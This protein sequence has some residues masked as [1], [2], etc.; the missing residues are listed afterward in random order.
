M[1][2]DVFSDLEKSLHSGGNV[3]FSQFRDFH[4][5]RLTR[6]DYLDLSSEVEKIIRL[7]DA[8]SPPGEPVYFLFKNRGLGYASILAC[9]ISGRTFIPLSMKHPLNHIARTVSLVNSRVL[10][11]DDSTISTATCIQKLVPSLDI[12]CVDK[13]GVLIRGNGSMGG[14][15]LKRFNDI[16]YVLFTSG[17]TGSPKG[18]LIERANLNHYLNGV[19]PVIS[20]EKNDKCT[21]MFDLN[22]DLAIG[23][24]LS[25]I[26][27]GGSLYPLESNELP[28]IE[29]FL[30][31]FEPTI[32]S[33]T[34]STVR[35]IQ[36]L[37]FLNK[38]IGSIRK[39]F[40]G[41]E[42]LTV[43]IAKY[44]KSKCPQSQIHNFY[45]PTE[46]TINVLHYEWTEKDQINVPLGRAIPS[47]SVRIVN[48]GGQPA[49]PKEVGEINVGGAQVARGYLNET[50]DTQSPFF[51]V[52]EAR[53]YR[54]GDFG[55]INS[56]G[57]L[58][59][60]G[61]KDLQVKIQ[62]HRIELGEIESA[63]STWMPEAHIM[64]MELDGELA[65]IIEVE[66]SQEKM[67]LLF[68]HLRKC[69]PQYMQPTK[70][71]LIS[72]WPLTINGKTDRTALKGA[73]L[74]GE[75]RVLFEK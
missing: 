66:L 23:E 38:Y 15:V 71:L 47:N 35:M 60:V 74:L 59:F 58:E 30:D 50:T 42:K 73:A 72:P 41:G 13:S 45:G 3:I 1:G 49:G 5:N 2:C 46:T 69:L 56:F 48:D 37:G 22:F 65:L 25:C 11:A 9:L 61:R 19:A 24:I 36:N 28:L 70:L 68:S 8:S 12:Q 31:K 7:M 55:F 64:A 18:V 29:T 53:W 44:W 52:G 32:W 51:H 33:S 75:A 10:L 4:L 14:A 57:D 26:L 16:A 21:Q 40:F 17:S 34:P 27:A 62:G 43:S 54:T 63:A 39:S 6:W 67:K 20:L